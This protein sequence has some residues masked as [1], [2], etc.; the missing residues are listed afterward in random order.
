LR[1]NRLN[2][3]VDDDRRRTLRHGISSHG[4]RPGEL[5]NVKEEIPNMLAIIFH[6]NGIPTVFLYV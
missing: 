3:K 4:L 2:E 6:V 5:T 1:R